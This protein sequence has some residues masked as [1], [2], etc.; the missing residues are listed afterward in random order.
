MTIPWTPQLH[1]GS[2]RYLALAE[3][4]AS[5]VRW[6]QL[7]PGERLP[8]HREL[9]KRLG[10]TVGTVSRGYAEAEK[11][12]LVVGEVGRGTYVRSQKTPDPWGT[13]EGLGSEG[14]RDQSTQFDPVD[15]TFSLPATVPEEGPLLAETLQEISR[16][17]HIGRLLV[18]QP[19]TAL[20]HQKAA[21]NTWLARLGLGI[22]DK[23]ILVTAGSQHGLNVAL[24]ALFTPGQTV[25]TG[26]LTYPSIK[27]QARALGL[28]L[29]G[30]EL[31]D[32]GLIPE[33]VE[34]ACAR[35]PKPAGIYVVPTLQNPTVATMSQARRQEI[36]RIVEAHGLWLIED[37]IHA[38]LP[39]EPYTPIAAIAPER[40]VYLASVG[41][42]LAPGLR[43]GYL[44]APKALY[45]RVLATIHSTIWMPAPLMVEVTSRWLTNGIGDTLIEAKKNEA[46]RRH[47]MVARHLQSVPEGTLVRAA[48]RSYHYWVELP[49]PL[50]SDEVVSQARA[51]GVLLLGAGAFAVGRRHI[52]HAVRL[53][54]G[55]PTLE[56]LEHGLGI[57]TD[58][59]RGGGT[60]AY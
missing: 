38:F 35:E 5:A 45:G 49:E 1:E 40:T 59:L 27:S 31:D 46:E 48:P 21:A 56:G 20:A 10:V 29:H 53:C 4:I 22:E 52:P 33:A 16:D 54:V 23:D 18:Y 39:E 19:T 8:T 60:P 44:V 15:L 9:A 17:P 34:R 51:R 42:C 57:V 2:P 6:E 58:L 12:G 43:T 50:H 24:T 55:Q 30:I 32:E 14:P 26:S 3:A 7:R 28:R 37:D 47:A 41:K 11:R 36:A 13:S 25:L